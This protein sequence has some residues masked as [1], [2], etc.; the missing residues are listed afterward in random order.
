MQ[1][2]CMQDPFHGAAD[3]DGDDAEE[4]E[5]ITPLQQVHKKGRTRANTPGGLA[6]LMT[7]CLNAAA[8]PQREASLWLE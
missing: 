2:V 4:E 1:S 7:V 6:F 8:D 3:V 5:D